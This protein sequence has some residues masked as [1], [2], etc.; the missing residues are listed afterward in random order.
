MRLLILGSGGGVGRHLVQQSESRG[1]AITVLLRPER[2]VE[3]PS[4]AR[5]VRG[6]LDDAAAL[7]DALEG[8]DAVASS[9]GM[10]RRNPANPWS[11]S[12]SPPDLTSGAATSLIAGMRR[13][14]VPRIVAVSAA[15]VGD[16]YAGLNVLMRGF[17]ATTMIGAAYRDLGEMEAL[18]AASGL[19]WLCPR[20]TRLTDGPATGS[21]RVVDGFSVNAAIARSD[22]ATWMLDALERSE[23]PAPEWGGRTPQ[24]SG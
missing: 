1:H 15:G 16:S 10:Q 9:V 23:W 3:L 5:V 7:A 13:A 8:V 11:A 20:P 22:V 17:L 2:E 6:T 24:I 4:A 14:G 21:A 18:L 19:D 12:I